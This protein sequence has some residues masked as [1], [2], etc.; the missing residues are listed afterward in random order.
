MRQ[1]RLTSATIAIQQQCG[2][3]VAITLPAG[4]E[5]AIADRV[6]TDWP[7]PPT[8]IEALWGDKTVMVF[9][10]DLMARGEGVIP[11]SN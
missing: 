9:L 7:L 2:K 10:R 1:F 8:L 11:T 6:N 4:A 5:L 3:G